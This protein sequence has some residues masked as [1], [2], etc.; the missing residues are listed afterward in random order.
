LAAEKREGFV[1]LIIQDNGKGIPEEAQSK[2]FNKYTSYTTFGTASE[3]GSG[4]GLLLCK[5]LVERNNGTIWFESKAG[6]GTSFYF[7]VPSIKNEELIAV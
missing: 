2:I 6:V 4:L 1:I 3:K 5:E 7:T